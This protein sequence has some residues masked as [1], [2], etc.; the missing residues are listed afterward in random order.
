MEDAGSLKSVESCSL[1][2]IYFDFSLMRV[3]DLKK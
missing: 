2:G 1:V 3:D